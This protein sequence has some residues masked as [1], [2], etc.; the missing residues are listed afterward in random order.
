MLISIFSFYMITY[1]RDPMFVI[2]LMHL[3]TLNFHFNADISQF[4]TLRLHWD[5]TYNNLKKKVLKCLLA[6]AKLFEILCYLRNFKLQIQTDKEL[7]LSF[8]LICLSNENDFYTKYIVQNR[9]KIE[10]FKFIL[11]YIN[12]F[13]CFTCI[14]LSYF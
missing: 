4:F 8:S 5:K 6:I 14:S 11:L 7:C 2:F 10:Y 9:R 13:N 1:I 12:N 3:K